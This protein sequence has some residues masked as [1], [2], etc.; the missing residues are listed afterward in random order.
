MVEF[1][2][3]MQRKNNGGRKIV[4]RPGAKSTGLNLRQLSTRR[5]ANKSGTGSAHLTESR[6]E[7]ENRKGLYAKLSDYLA[8]VISSIKSDKLFSL[9]PGIGL[10]EK[11]IDI[12]TPIDTLF[13]KAI[14]DDESYDIII[15]HS[16]NVAICAIKM[17][18]QLG[19]SKTR[20]VEIGLIG[21]LHD[22]GMAKIPEALIY[23]PNLTKKEFSVFKQ[24]PTYSYEILSVFK[25]GYAY[26]P[27][28]TLQIY[29]RIDGSG[30]PRGLQEDEIHDYA[31]IVGL[32][33]IYEALIHSRPQREKILHFY[34]IK[35]IV[36]TGK[37]KF[38]QKYL[39]ALLNTFSIFPIYSYVRL[40]SGA[41]GKVIRTYTDQPMRPKLQIV[42]DSQKKRVLTE[43]LINL[44]DHSLL[45]IVDSVSEQE[46]V[47]I[48]EESYLVT[49]PGRGTKPG[50]KAGNNSETPKD[51]PVKIASAK[52]TG[53]DK[54]QSRPSG[55]LKA[56][57]GLLVVAGLLLVAG[58]AWEFTG[59]VPGIEKVITKP[60]MEKPAVVPKKD[61]ATAAS[62]EDKIAKPGTKPVSEQPPA[63]TETANDD[64]T[65]KLTTTGSSQVVEKSD[66]SIEKVKDIGLVTAAAEKSEKSGASNNAVDSLVVIEVPKSGQ[67]PYSI[68]LASY[69]DLKSI[70]KAQS[71]F[72]ADGLDSFWVKVDL[73]G[74]GIWFRLFSGQFASAKHAQAEIEER[75]LQ[76]A[77]SKATRYA[78]WVG[79]FM[80]QE[81]IKQKAN[82]LA[83]LGFSSYSAP[84]D[85]NVQHLYVGAFYTEKGAQDQVAAL[86]RVGIKSKVV[87]R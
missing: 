17:A 7:I 9:E 83:E 61:A 14:H 66:N 55:A 71:L 21:L 2:K 79:G 64:P 37:D 12:K 51:K 34:A 56:K 49:K 27:E 32:V 75:Q 41:I 43:R 47:E 35:E 13:L 44:P 59:G 48:S 86:E 4:K 45:Y 23:K 39:K 15:N 38:Q 22:V 81:E 82:T 29:E 58:I 78:A 19:F 5:N 46:L 80:D 20:Q 65:E 6:T 76:G 57:K 8:L 62:I 74:D 60:P 67:Y 54:L 33:D 70:Q 3:V 10:L 85:E 84:A 18:G 50:E 24:R 11:I 72:D 40:N 30:Y 25:D 1:S 73:G 31:Q 68:L 52:S 87:E 16:V 69:K 77:L 28:C 63:V 42:Y 53:K 36:K 26:L